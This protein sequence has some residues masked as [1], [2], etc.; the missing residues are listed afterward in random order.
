MNTEQALQIV[1]NMSN[2]CVTKGGILTTI[3]EAATVAMSIQV[4]TATID[5]LNK[6]QNSKTKK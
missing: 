5:D 3:D 1:R 2:L 4:L 6:L